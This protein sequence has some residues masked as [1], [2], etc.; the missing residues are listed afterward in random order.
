MRLAQYAT[1][2]GIPATPSGGKPFVWMDVEGPYAN[3]PFWTTSVAVNR[4]VYAGAV[5]TLRGN[6][7]RVGVYT[8]RNDSSANDWRQ[9]MGD[10][11]L[12]LTQNWVF[13]VSDSET[14]GAMCAKAISSTG[15]PAVMVQQQPTSARPDQVYDVNHTC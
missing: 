6:G 5:E 8:D 10:W 12:L 9:I 15:G 3:G 4:A 13:R 1:G 14:A 7:Y 2:L 11:R